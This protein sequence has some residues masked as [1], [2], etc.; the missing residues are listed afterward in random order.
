M[1]PLKNEL[2]DFSNCRH[3]GLLAEFHLLCIQNKKREPEPS[4]VADLING[5]DKVL[6]TIF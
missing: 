6:K 4:E 1:K 3:L 5:A 2:I